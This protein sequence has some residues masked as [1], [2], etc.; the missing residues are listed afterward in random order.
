MSLL[1]LREEPQS[2][3]TD[4]CI[5]EFDDEVADEVFEALTA[6]TTRTVLA[7]IYDHP[8]TSTDIRDEI[9]TSLQ[10]VHYHL[11]KLEEAGLIEPASIGY[12]EKGTEM[13]VYAPAHEAVALVAGQDAHHHHLS[14]FFS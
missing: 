6:S 1:P 14:E 3:P 7:T 4:P 13:A 9:D 11:Q 10:N 2:T 8:S 12:S 5:L